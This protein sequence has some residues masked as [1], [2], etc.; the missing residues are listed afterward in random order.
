VRLLGVTIGSDLSV[1]FAR[2]RVEKQMAKLEFDDEGSRLVEVF[3]ASLGARAR[4][5]RILQVLALKPGDRVLDVGSGPGHQAFEMASIVGDT[6]RVDGV[7]SA[8][9]ALEIARNRC[10][11]LGNVSFQLGNASQLPFDDATFDAVMSSQVFEYLDDIAGG[12][13]EMFRVLKSGGRVVIHDTDWGATLWYSSDPGRM[14]RI[15]KI[16]DG[17]L[18]NPHLPQTL[19]RKLTNAGFKN[20]RAEAVVQLETGY[21]PRSVSAI[22]MKFVAGYVVSQGV[23]QSEAEAWA[24]ELRA[25]GSSGEYFF[26]ANEYLFT[27]EKP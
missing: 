15:M 14:A 24:D 13:T 10:S 18:A 20:V 25:L 1:S 8:E 3:N 22:L 4:R 17:H 5:L 9:S 6:G 7:D 16:W 12:L 26:S 19:G 2:F 11:N 21:D 23:W 27:A